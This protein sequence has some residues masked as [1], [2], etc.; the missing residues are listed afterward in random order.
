[1]VSTYSRSCACVLVLVSRN[2]VSIT[3]EIFMKL[4]MCIM[5]LKVTPHLYFILYYT[6]MTVRTSEVAVTLTLIIVGHEIF[7]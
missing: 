1:M 7:Y 6:N 4:G 2:N 5:S 3:R